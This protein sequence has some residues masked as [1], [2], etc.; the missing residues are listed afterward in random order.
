METISVTRQFNGYK[1]KWLTL[2]RVAL[3]II[4]LLKGIS[5]FMDNTLLTSLLQRT[6]LAFVGNNAEIWASVITYFNLLGGVFIAAGLFTRFMCFILIPILIAAVYLNFS[7]GIGGGAGDL[8]LS[9]ISL[10]LLIVFAKIGSGNI[11]ADE[12]F[13]TYTHAGERDGYTRK[14]FQ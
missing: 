13:R 4:I 14:F 8:L 6:N 2:L 7:L 1:P 11:S 9:V 5:F 10:V 3:G 12:F